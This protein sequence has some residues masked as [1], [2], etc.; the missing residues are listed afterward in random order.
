MA[1]INAIEAAT[2]MIIFVFRRIVIYFNVDSICLTLLFVKGLKIYFS[3]F[4]LL[5]QAILVV[6]HRVADNVLGIDAAPPIA[7][8]SKLKNNF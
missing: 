1:L 4:N 5:S 6:F 7:L 3:Y 8:Q 2:V